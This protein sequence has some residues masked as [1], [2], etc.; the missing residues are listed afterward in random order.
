MTAT[1]SV[2]KPPR[3][4]AW[5][6]PD[7]LK[8]QRDVVAAAGGDPSVVGD[9]PFRFLRLPE[10]ERRVGLKRTTIYRKI[11]EGSFPSPVTLGPARV[12]T[13]SEAA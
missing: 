12:L 13:T 5:R 3:A 7:I 10:V 8:W 2:A 9:E 11:G 6:S 4:K 1:I